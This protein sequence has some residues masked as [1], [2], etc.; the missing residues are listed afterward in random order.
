MAGPLPGKHLF[1]PAF[2]VFK[3]E[4]PLAEHVVRVGIRG[5][6]KTFHLN[7]LIYFTGKTFKLPPGNGPATR[8]PDWDLTAPVR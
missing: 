4:P 6:K 3:I 2:P 7:P 1:L 5:R 8:Y